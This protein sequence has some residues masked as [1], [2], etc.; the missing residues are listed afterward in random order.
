MKKDFKHSVCLIAVFLIGNMIISFP[1]GEGQRASLWGFVLCLA[2]SLLLVLF[3]AYLQS[4]NNFS[5][6]IFKNVGALSTICFVFFCLL[7]LFCYVVC[8][9][10]YIVLVDTLRLQNTSRFLIAP[11]FILLTL[12]L[13]T[14]KTK[15]FKSFSLVSFCVVL[16][17]SIFMF[18]LSVSQAKP[19]LFYSNLPFNLGQTATQAL[20]YFIHSFGQIIIVLLF[21]GKKDRA[22][23]KRLLL[24]GI[25]AG[26]AV[27]F[28]CLLQVLFHLGPFVTQL[29]DFPYA[30]ATG[31]VTAAKSYS[32]LDG[33]T[34]Y[35]Y[36]VCSLIKASV[37][38]CCVLR[39]AKSV[40]KYLS[41]ILT[42][43]FTLSAFL[44]STVKPFYAVITGDTFNLVFLC[45]EIA[46]PLLIL[47][48][49]IRLRKNAQYHHTA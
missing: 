16:I 29:L 21:I 44:F 49:L 10:E 3:Y 41:Y 15:I 38:L 26:S 11:I 27:F 22:S 2:V 39:I 13:A 34:Y 36:F 20:T 28:I 23:S 25:S 43:V 1:K 40:N 5:Q 32:R 12:L 47:V 4:N 8:C 45:L 35:I 46:V 33:F 18:A 17:C 14:S 6:A 24:L 42:A 37:I 9:K 30:A 31:S 19:H 7:C 48:Q